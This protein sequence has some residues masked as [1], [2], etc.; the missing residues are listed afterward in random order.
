MLE[1]VPPGQHATNIRPTANSAGNPIAIATSQPE[2]GM[3]VYCEIAAI[4]TT[5]GVAN[6]V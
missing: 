3:I 5:R 1:A 2:S 6:K 4:S